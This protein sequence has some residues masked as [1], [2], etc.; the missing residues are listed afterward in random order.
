MYNIVSSA[1]EV[2]GPLK[3]KYPTTTIHPSEFF[4]FLTLLLLIHRSFKSLVMESINSASAGP[5]AATVMLPG[6]T[7][8]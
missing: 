6:S 4:Y 5:I 2:L 7:W 1:M 3:S 8:V